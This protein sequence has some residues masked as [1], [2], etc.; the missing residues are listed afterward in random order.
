MIKRFGSIVKEILTL[1][2]FER[3]KK[4]QRLFMISLVKETREIKANCEP[5]FIRLLT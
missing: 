2:F 4:V 1:Y 3:T 5:K